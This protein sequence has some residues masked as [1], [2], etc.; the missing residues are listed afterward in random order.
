MKQCAILSALES[1]VTDRDEKKPSP[2]RT[3]L[4]GESRWALGLGRG[5]GGVTLKLKRAFHGTGLLN[6]SGILS[7]R[8]EGKSTLRSY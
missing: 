7:S 1:G 3:V 6:P 2:S 8:S 4:T 5:V